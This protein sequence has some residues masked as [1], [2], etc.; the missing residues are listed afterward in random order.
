MSF[1]PHATH[2]RA[3]GADFKVVVLGGDFVPARLL[4]IDKKCVWDPQLVEHI[5]GVDDVICVKPGEL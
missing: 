4:L 3:V 5:G 2:D 1:L